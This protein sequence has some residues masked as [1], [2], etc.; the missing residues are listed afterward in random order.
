MQKT[1]C[2]NKTQSLGVQIQDWN[3]INAKT[4][5]QLD[6]YVHTFY[7]CGFNVFL[8]RTSTLEQ[9]LEIRNG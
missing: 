2:V 8:G 7:M 4:L 9:K 6:T 5:M 1:K 3:S